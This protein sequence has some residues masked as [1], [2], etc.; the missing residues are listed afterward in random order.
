LLW[1]RAGDVELE[2]RSAASRIAD[3]LAQ[4]SVA[5]IVPGAAP[6]PS[7]AGASLVPGLDLIARLSIDAESYALGKTLAELNVRARTG[8]NV[9]AIHRTGGPA[10]LP[11]GHERLESGDALAIA[12]SPEALRDTA[13][14]L[15]DGP[16]P[17]PAAF[18]ASSTE[19]ST[20]DVAE[21]A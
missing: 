17:A 16:R 4:Q 11:T 20:E 14:L 1:R 13:I 3:A 5:T 2:F 9:I 19:P 10:I 18:I 6:E 7:L 21:T 8:A 12:A 15:H